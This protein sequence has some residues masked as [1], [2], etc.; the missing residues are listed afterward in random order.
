MP[1]IQE[2]LPIVAKINQIGHPGVDKL[3][4]MVNQQYYWPGIGALAKRKSAS[5]AVKDNCT[6][7]Q[8]ASKRTL[9]PQGVN[10]AH[11]YL[12]TA[13]CNVG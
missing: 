5:K 3:R 6:D 7:C 12:Y 2:R 10:E 8:R 11:I 9:I 1:A 4:T 13:R